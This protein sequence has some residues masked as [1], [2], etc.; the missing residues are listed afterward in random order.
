MLLS[1]NV[2]YRGLGSNPEERQ[3]IYREYV[4]TP[5]AYE[6]IVDQYFKERVL[7]WKC[8]PQNRPRFENLALRNS[9]QAYDT[10]VSDFM[11]RL[12]LASK[13]KTE[14]EQFLDTNARFLEPFGNNSF[15]YYPYGKP[16]PW[17]E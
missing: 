7:I 12:I 9:Q 15:K 13:T 16:T 5:R 2:L 3:G 14:L 11:T 17:K 10:A 8:P 6:L 1:E 4:Q